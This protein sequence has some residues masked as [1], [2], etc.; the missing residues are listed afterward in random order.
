M[1]HLASCTKVTGSLS[2][3]VKRTGRD[4]EHPR[5]SIAK[6]RLWVELYPYNPPVPAW[7]VTFHSPVRLHGVHGYKFTFPLL[8][9]KKIL[10]LVF[11]LTCHVSTVVHL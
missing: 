9:F 5:P 3:G 2:L 1:A 8:K 6:G 7:H 10:S 11:I 4:A